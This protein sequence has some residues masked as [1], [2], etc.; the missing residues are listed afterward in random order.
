VPYFDKF[1][2]DDN[3]FGQGQNP[4]GQGQ[5]P[6]HLGGGTK[7]SSGYSYEPSP[8]AAPSQQQAAS[9]YS[10]PG[11]SAVA[12]D[13]GSDF[14]NFDRYWNA[15]QG[16][17][18]NTANTVAGGVE[19]AANDAAT[20]L[21]DLSS[22]FGANVKAGT[23]SGPQNGSVVQTAMG[24]NVLTV[25]GKRWE[26]P[27][28]SAPAT[29]T[30]T[31]SQSERTLT[32]GGRSSADPFGQP[33]TA[34]P[35]DPNAITNP[36]PTPTPAPPVLTRA[37]LLKGS[38]QK[39]TGPLGLQDDPGFDAVTGK[40]TDAASQVGALGNKDKL[41]ALL[42]KNYGSAPVGSGGNELD[43]LLTNRAGRGRFDAI[44]KGYG[45]LED[46]VGRAVSAGDN[47]V[48]TAQ[49]D[50]TDAAG[51]YQGLLDQFDAAAP[52]TAAETG[53]APPPSATGPK[54]GKSFKDY[55]TGNEAAHTVRDIGRVLNPIG[56][57]MNAAGMKSPEDYMTPQYEEQFG[58]PIGNSSAVQF[59]RR[60][61]GSTPEQQEKVY[62]SL[63]NEEVAALEKMSFGEQTQF[64]SKRLNSLLGVK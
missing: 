1:K 43:S 48:K 40:I 34:R 33:A 55:N 27:D 32:G 5:N 16:A 56:W 30:S 36:S 4:F 47:Q 25:G 45:D 53:A 19:G 21:S 3:P 37:D 49:D 51:Q 58:H 60:M 13:S 8:G 9:P 7:A 54:S 6:F 14:V 42:S 26:T 22:Q 38:E 28:A 61:P 10:A 44:Q 50:T 57:L 63:S 18:E 62:N 23:G 17:A 64:L 52:K 35:T 20:G 11:G 39:Y 41:G 12:G 24:G 46:R 2:E 29:A 15:N 59:D 31:T